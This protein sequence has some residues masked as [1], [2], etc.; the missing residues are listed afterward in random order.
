MHE[1]ELCLDHNV[2]PRAATMRACLAIA[3]DAGVNETRID[4]PEGRIVESVFGE[5]SGKVVF[6]QHVTIGD[7]LVKDL[8]TFFFLK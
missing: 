3:G 1:T 4:G 8:N 5:G 2:I 6:N 7:K